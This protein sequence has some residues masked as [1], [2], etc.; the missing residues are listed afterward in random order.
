MAIKTSSTVIKALAVLDALGD[1]GAPMSATE[2]SAVT[3]FDRATCYRLLMTFRDAQYVLLDSATNKF[4]LSFKV[5]SLARSLLQEDREVEMVREVMRMV[6]KQATE[7]CHYSVLDGINSIITLR[8][9]G[10]QVVS[11]DF[12]VGE[13]ADLYCTAGGKVFLAFADVRF[14][15]EYL[16]GS[17][18][19]HTENT[20]VDAARLRRELIEIRAHGVAYDREELIPGLRCLAAPIFEADGTV[21]SAIAMSGP[22]SRYTSERIAELEVILREGARELTRRRGGPRWSI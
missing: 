14:V 9:K 13:R 12:G 20:L 11:V 18:V 17:R 22:S 2:V 7:T 5:V 1:E 4:S 6:S 16:S 15:Q 8:E 19:S 10:K 21:R 3:G